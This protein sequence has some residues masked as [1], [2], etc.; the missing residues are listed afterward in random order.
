MSRNSNT[1]L[2]FK[3]VSDMVDQCNCIV[4]IIKWIVKSSEM[5]ESGD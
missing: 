2:I 4:S 5:L 3:M 1:S